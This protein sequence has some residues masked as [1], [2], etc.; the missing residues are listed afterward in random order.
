MTCPRKSLIDAT[1]TPYYHC[2]A[3]CVRRAFLCGKDHVTG[4]D[5]AHRKQWVVGRLNTLASG[6]IQ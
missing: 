2:M 1:S 6:A 3:R 4:Q 5:Y